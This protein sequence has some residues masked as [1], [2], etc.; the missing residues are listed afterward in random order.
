M[1]ISGIGGEYDP[2]LKAGS[3][4]QT[5]TSQYLCMGAGMTTTSVDWT[6]CLTND[7]TAAGTQNAYGFIGIN[8]TGAMSSGSESCKCRMFG[9]SKAKCAS[10]VAAWSFVEA[11]IGVS[12]TTFRGHIQQIDNS[13]SI[14]AA[15]M[16]ISA[17]TVVIGRAL[18]DGS[19]NSVITVF[20]NPS[21]YDRSLLAD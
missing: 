3:T 20:V 13:V 11:Y 12:T 16:S 21:M 4:V 5:T 8:Q 9:Y 17:Q 1:A 7:S 18:E 10:S 6:A 2:T 19:T 14:V 15:T